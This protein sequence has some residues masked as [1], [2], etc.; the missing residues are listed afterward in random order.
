MMMALQVWFLKA[1]QQTSFPSRNLP[2]PSVLVHY[3]FEDTMHASVPPNE[4][5]SVFSFIGFVLSVIPFYWHFKGTRATIHLIGLQSLT[6]NDN[7]ARNT[8][9][10]L[11]M[12]WTGLG[13]LLQ[14][15]NSIVW[16]KNMINRAPV[17]CDIGNFLNALSLERSFTLRHP[18]WQQPVFKPRLMLLC[19]LLHS[20]SIASSIGLLG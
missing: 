9:T 13:C 15:V 11:F 7:V 19:L 14:C 5:Y 10:C 17:Y 4:L 12:I 18:H 1:L 2:L 8:G 20:A 3:T 6:K 16:N